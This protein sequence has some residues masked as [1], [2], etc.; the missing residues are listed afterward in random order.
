MWKRWSGSPTSRVGRDSQESAS[1]GSAINV[2]RRRYPPVLRATLADSS[3]GRDP[4]DG[5]ERTSRVWPASS[6]SMGT[7]PPVDAESP[8]GGRFLHGRQLRHGF[9]RGVSRTPRHH[10]D[11]TARV[12]CLVAVPDFG[13]AR[14][15]RELL[16]AA[17]WCVRFIAR[18]AEKHLPKLGG[19]HLRRVGKPDRRTVCSVDRDRRSHG[20]VV[21]TGGHRLSPG[22]RLLAPLDARLR[23]EI[24]TSG[25][26][27][28]E[29]A[30]PLRPWPYQG[31]L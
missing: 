10:P 29:V 21:R 6:V 30:N 7:A 24:G 4:P 14:S 13:I 8:R 22:S 15:Q 3:L 26:R 11:R 12:G 9:R 2:G 23:G 16:G 28:L 1:T 27:H 18:S 19:N 31:L 20:G 5:M 17:S 25:C